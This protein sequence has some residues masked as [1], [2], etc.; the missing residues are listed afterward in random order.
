MYLTVYVLMLYV[1]NTVCF[2]CMYLT[3]LLAYVFNSM[4]NT[5]YGILQHF[6]NRILV[7][8]EA[9]VCTGVCTCF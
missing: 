9:G 4:D 8:Y 5:V 7:L 6:Y 2:M 3:C 1:F